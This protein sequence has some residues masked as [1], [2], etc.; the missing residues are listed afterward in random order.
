[1]FAIVWQ[2]RDSHYDLKVFQ[3]KGCP[4]SDCRSIGQA[5]STHQDLEAACP[6]LDAR[7][8]VKMLRQKGIKNMTVTC[9]ERNLEFF[10]VKFVAPIAIWSILANSSCHSS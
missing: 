6:D 2:L 8:K 1:M 5:K 10:P 9:V 7:Q 4:L 3:V